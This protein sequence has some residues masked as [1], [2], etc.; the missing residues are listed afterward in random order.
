MMKSIQVPPST[1]KKKKARRVFGDAVADDVV[2]CSLTYSPSPL[3]LETI[4]ES[5]NSLTTISDNEKSTSCIEERVSIDS[6]D[7]SYN[8]VSAKEN[9]FDTINNHRKANQVHQK[10][11]DNC[12]RSIAQRNRR[13]PM[14]PDLVKKT[15]DAINKATE[16]IR[17]MQQQKIGVGNSINENIA[18]ARQAKLTLIRQRAKQTTKEKNE[19]KENVKTVRFLLDETD[20]SKA[21]M[22]DLHRT[23]SSN[24]CKHRAARSNKEKIIR[25]Q[26]IDQESHFHSKVY[27]EHRNKLK[28]EKDRARRASN[29]AKAK[30]RENHEIGKQNLIMKRV[31]EEK[32]IHEE[33][34]AASLAFNNVRK[35]NAQ[36]RRKSFAF[37]SEHAKRI[38]DIYKEME[39]SRQEEENRSYELERAAAKDVEAY[40]KLLE[41]EKRQ[42]LAKRNQEYHDWKIRFQEESIMMQKREQAGFELNQA[43]NRDVDEY[44]KSLEEERRKSLAS[45]N[46]YARMQR[47]REEQL[48]KINRQK[49]QLSFE[50]KRES[51]KDV[52]AYKAK[53]VEEQIQSAKKRGVKHR[54]IREK[55]SDQEKTLFKQQQ[56]SYDLD[57]QA[58]HDVEQYKRK[59]EEE[60]RNS[61]AWR[62]EERVRHANVLKEILSI[63]Q[64]KEHESFVLKWAGESDANEY[65]R[66]LEKQRRQSL[67][68]RGQN[69]RDRRAIELTEKQ[70]EVQQ[71]HRDEVLRADD[72]KNMELY[73][74]ECADRDRRSLVYRGK[75]TTLRRLREEEITEE[76]RENDAK[77][78]N[79]DMQ[80]WHDVQEYVSDCNYRR[81]LSL[82]YRAK[83]KRR[84]A[85]WKN[86]QL[87]EERDALSKQ[88]RDRLIDQHHIEAAKQKER[89]KIALEALRHLER[90]TTA[91]HNPFQYF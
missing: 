61:I 65:L 40:K 6:I 45:R 69:S 37:R 78:F 9:S 42:S 71:R 13:S 38:L 83:E 54:E 31:Q 47:N 1:G 46:Q 68:G 19:W 24:Y 53:L 33:R 3:R 66:D 5:S 79:L 62:N 12:I 28:E 49:E 76:Q 39:K 56:E 90:C 63:V 81:R 75:E 16:S 25:L 85:Q 26:R 23:I 50:L 59:Q 41:T 15:Q 20:K 84:H 4:E 34:Y 87:Q 57:R 27:R 64:E 73:L 10:P 7:T 60:R 70:E 48:E 89:A 30:L 18:A 2:N 91:S 35:E 36:A 17:C 22:L 51:E 11:S 44:K 77:A 8:S 21:E 55:I 29:A 43:A 86:K 58:W 82:A 14:R 72:S 74:K 67:Q 32:A 52:E 80:A 88:V